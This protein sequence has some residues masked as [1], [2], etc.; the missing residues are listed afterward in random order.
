MICCKA[1][2]RTAFDCSGQRLHAHPVVTF[3]QTACDICHTR[4]AYRAWSGA[5]PAAAWCNMR[6]HSESSAQ[7]FWRCA[8]AGG[9]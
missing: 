6:S 4:I 1:R 5:H 3:V 8:S 9:S 7:F 2:T